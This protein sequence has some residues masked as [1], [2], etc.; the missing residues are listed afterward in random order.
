MFTDSIKK[1]FRMLF[2]AMLILI[3]VACS[4]EKTTTEIVEV[5]DAEISATKETNSETN[6]SKPLV[7]FKTQIQ[8]AND[9]GP[10]YELMARQGN[11]N[12]T[13]LIVPVARRGEVSITTGM[14]GNLLVVSLGEEN[15]FA[16][17][18]IPPDGNIDTEINLEPD[19][20]VLYAEVFTQSGSSELLGVV[21]LVTETA[22]AGFEVVE[23][24]DSI[25]Q[26]V[27]LGITYLSV[28]IQ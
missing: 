14:L 1:H 12:P 10:N 26:T 6:N 24:K 9:L 18:E 20:Y 2:I 13:L 4:S 21:S 5:N 3:F 15:D 28:P 11:S 25:G 8:N 19:T 7:I 16:T 22:I 23:D 17:V 27:D